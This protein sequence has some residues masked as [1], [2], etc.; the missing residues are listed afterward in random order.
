MKI[1]MKMALVCVLALLGFVACAPDDASAGPVWRVISF[2][3]RV[4]VRGVH[5]RQERREARRD[6]RSGCHSEAQAASGCHGQ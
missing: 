4:I 1:W 2:P 5:R 6:A 3:G